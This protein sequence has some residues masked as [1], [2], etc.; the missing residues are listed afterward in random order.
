M[1]RGVIAS[2]RDLVPIRPL[3]RL[4]AMSIAERQAHRFLALVGVDGPPVPEWAVADLP[5]V[6]VRR[7]SPFPV[8]G[9]TEWSSGRWL[10]VLNGGEPLGRQ[11]FSLMHEFK[12]AIDHRFVDVIYRG[13]PQDEQA[14]WIEQL[15]DFFASCVLMPRPWVK[16][17]YTSGTQRLVPLAT[18]FGVSQT[19]MRVRLSQIGL[20]D[21]A[22]RCGR[23]VSPQSGLRTDSEAD[24]WNY[25]R[26]SLILTGT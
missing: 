12:H 16:R 5:R 7:A 17:V 3:R 18:R 1:N 9:A 19:A 24:S 8:S 26:R 25:T 13:I 4:E 10:I 6:E 21:P 15:C 2:L 20:V 14:A 22:P 23:S 11:R